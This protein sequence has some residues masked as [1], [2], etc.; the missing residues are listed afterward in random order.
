MYFLIH[1][2]YKQNK[3]VEYWNRKTEVY[4]INLSL[5]LLWPNNYLQN[6][7]TFGESLY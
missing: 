2:N 6:V 5:G 7:F 3:F 1:F 4:F